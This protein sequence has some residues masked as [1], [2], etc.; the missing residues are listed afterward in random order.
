[1]IKKR[2]K[3]DLKPNIG[4]ILKKSMAILFFVILW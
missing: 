1:M 4:H 3:S 2:S